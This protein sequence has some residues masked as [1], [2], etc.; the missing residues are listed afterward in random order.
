[1]STSTK[2][3]FAAAYALWIGFVL[4]LAS[5]PPVSRDA[6]TH[7]LAVPKLWAE[8]GGIVEIPHVLFSYYPQL[9]DVLYT[10]PMLAGNDIAPKYLHFLFGLLT[11]VMIFLFVRRR[12]GSAWGAIAGL[13]YLTIPLITKLS[14]TVY[15]D[16]GLMCFTT[17]AI[18]SA[19]IWLED[20]S[21]IRWLL[22][23]AVC[24][25]LALSTK[26]NALVS[27]VILGLLVPLFYLRTRDDKKSEQINTVKYGLVFGIISLLV[28]SPWM[29]RNIALTGN[30]IYPLGAGPFQATPLEA[31]AYSDEMSAEEHAEFAIREQ[32]VN[33]EKALGPLLTRKFVHEESLPYTLLIPAR[34]FYE[35][36]DDSPKYFDGRLNALLLILPLLLIYLGRQV[37][38]RPVESSFFGAYAVLM[39]FLVFMTKDMRIRWISTIVPP[40]IV[41]STYSIY[42]MHRW[43]LSSGRSPRVANG[44]VAGV[45]ALFLVP[46]LAYAASLL[47]KI[48]PLPYVTGQQSYEAYRRAHLPEYG[49]VAVANEAVAEDG[50]LL[51]LHMGYRSYYFDVD[52]IVVNAVFASL[53]ASSSSA[54]ELAERLRRLGYTHI[55]TRDDFFLNWLDSTDESVKRRVT[56]FL[57]QYVVPVAG[58]NGFGLYEVVSPQP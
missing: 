29:I 52:A 13:M 27:F 11:A 48:D 41:L 21:R 38:F 22:I 1:M 30:P 2:T 24:S 40:L 26:Y 10:L 17:A 58:E 39:V 47:G 14:V 37:G 3:A 5:V 45:V 8:A 32:M 46:N 53:A 31:T 35:G 12:I 54:T 44:A 51:V 23:A 43:L 42:A 16:L 49:V 33:G 50:K 25:G 34:V 15:V 4:V 19:V 56:E 57:E 9:L 55:F 36:R 6:L 20:T 7:H 18:F 28:F